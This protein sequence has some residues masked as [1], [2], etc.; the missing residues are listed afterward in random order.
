ML[1]ITYSFLALVMWQP[2]TLP[3]TRCPST[4][5]LALCMVSASYPEYVKDRNINDAVANVQN[6]E[7]PATFGASV[8]LNCD[9]SLVEAA[10]EAAAGA[11]VTYSGSEIVIAFNSY[12]L[13]MGHTYN[14]VDEEALQLRAFAANAELIA[15]YLQASESAL[16][17]AN[18]GELSDLNNMDQ[19]V[20]QFQQGVDWRAV[21]DQAVIQRAAADAKRIEAIEGR[22]AAKDKLRVTQALASKREEDG[23]A[24]AQTQYQQAVRDAEEIAS[25]ERAKLSQQLSQVAV[26]EREARQAAERNMK[27]QLEEAKRAS[28][29]SLAAADADQKGALHKW[30]TA[31]EEA[32]AALRVA[33]ADMAYA[34]EQARAHEE[35]A[36][37]DSKKRSA[38][39]LAAQS[40]AKALMELLKQTQSKAATDVARAQQEK[41]DLEQQVEI[42]NRRAQKAKLAAAAALEEL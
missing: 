4:A 30:T 16:A 19:A 8:A 33:E 7:T 35:V 39:A 25:R 34:M 13:T 9:P 26:D 41:K 11:G 27:T 28:A 1:V 2:A 5:R 29:G 20:S 18:L 21:Y 37:L 14:T 40:E 22:A 10:T 42:A 3:A 32:L 38:A 36:R 17:F 6:T 15:E 23:L 12:K 24:L 31:E